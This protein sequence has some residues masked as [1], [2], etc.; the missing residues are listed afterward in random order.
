[1][2]ESYGSRNIE[3]EYSMVMVVTIIGIQQLLLW[4]YIDT[5]WICGFY[6]RHSCQMYI[7]LEVIELG[8]LYT[9][10]NF[11]RIFIFSDCGKQVAIWLITWDKASLRR[12]CP[13]SYTLWR[14]WRSKLLR[15]GCRSISSMY[16]LLSSCQILHLHYFCSIIL[17]I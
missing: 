10:F 16:H 11:Y 7:L 17:G 1:M 6:V 13:Q 14:S 3:S 5:V 8:W 15:T 2:F 4:K 9:F 12:G